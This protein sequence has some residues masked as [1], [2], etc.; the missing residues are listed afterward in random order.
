MNPRRLALAIFATT[1][2]MT[3]TAAFAQTVY[4]VQLGSFQSEAEAQGHWKKLQ[5]KFPSTFEPLSYAPAEIQLP[6]DDMVYFRTQAGPIPSREEAEQ[7]CSELQGKNFECYVAETAMFNADSKPEK[8]AS[9]PPAPKPEPVAAPAPAERIAEAPKAMPAPASVSTLPSPDKLRETPA[10]IPAAVAADIA[11]VPAEDT[12]PDLEELEMQFAAEDAAP[13]PVAS[14]PVS[15]PVPAPAPAPVVV[16]VAEA[17]PVRAPMPTK[18]P[19]PKKVERIQP[20]P[21]APVK[22]SP[23]KSFSTP[24]NESAPVSDFAPS[25]PAPTGAPFQTGQSSY[26]GSGNASSST[27]VASVPVTGSAITPSTSAN[28]QVNVAEAIPV[29]LSGQSSTA[30]SYS[31]GYGSFRGY[32]SQPAMHTALWAEISYFKTQKGALGYWNTLRQRDPAIPGGLRLRVTRPLMQRG[33]ELLS[34]RVGPFASVTAI[35]RLC[36]FTREENLRCNAV[37]DLGASVSG[38]AQRERRAPNAYAARTAG[39]TPLSSAGGY[40]VQL[41]SFTNLSA[42][43]QTWA[44]LTGLHGTVLSSQ[45]QQ[46][47]TPP[48]SSAARPMYRLRVGPYADSYAAVSLCNQLKTRGTFCAVVNGQ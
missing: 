29:P 19:A 48:M 8:L 31:K 21:A 45:P 27:N 46:M 26:A 30:A 20:A 11:N 35:R 16:P 18:L 6:P 5:Q 42:A 10:P 7:I 36:S 37:K 44:R 2:L 13:T 38:Y 17:V 39:I 22:S 3:G 33:S 43:Q 40:Y 1:S 41:G 24:A 15:A 23:L 25:S 14:A 9:A 34:L 28:A 12:L 4:T 47:V 32:P